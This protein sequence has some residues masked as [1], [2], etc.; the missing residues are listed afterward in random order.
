MCLGQ[1][2]A[3]SE[4]SVNV[5]NSIAFPLLLLLPSFGSW[6]VGPWRAGKISCFSLYSQSPSAVPGS[7]SALIKCVMRKGLASLD[8]IGPKHLCDYFKCIISAFQCCSTWVISSMLSKGSIISTLWRMATLE[9]R[10]YCT[11]RGPWSPCVFLMVDSPLHLS[12]YFAPRSA[13]PK[14]SLVPEASHPMENWPQD[15]KSGG[16]ESRGGGEGEILVM[17]QVD[18]APSK[19]HLVRSHLTSSEGTLAC[20]YEWD[21]CCYFHVIKEEGNLQWGWEIMKVLIFF[22]SQR[23]QKYFHSY[24][25]WCC[26]FYTSKNWDWIPG[27]KC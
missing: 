10:A 27:S 8:L 18:A 3:H 20:I 14:H 4:H 19:E 24:I 22:F 2:W 15:Q 5:R 13:L 21:P 16:Y 26:Q 6:A 12:V 7:E 1:C 23:N 17:C 25:F 11:L 9:E